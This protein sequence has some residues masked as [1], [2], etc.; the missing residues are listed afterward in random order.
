MQKRNV[1]QTGKNAF[2][3]LIQVLHISARPC[4]WFRCHPCLTSLIHIT[5]RE[6][7]FL[8]SRAWIAE[9]TPKTIPISFRRVSITIFYSKIIQSKLIKAASTC[10]P[11]RRLHW[12]RLPLSRNLL[13]FLTSALSSN[14][15]CAHLS[16]SYAYAFSRSTAGFRCVYTS[17]LT[18]R[19][20][21]DEATTKSRKK[22]FQTLTSERRR[23][24]HPSKTNEICGI[25]LCSVHQLSGV[26]S[27]RTRLINHI[28]CRWWTT[29]Y[30]DACTRSK[31]I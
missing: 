6:L 22:W 3:F 11:R 29:H 25:N 27:G 26:E 5:G 31:S 19:L 20:Q 17:S 4:L 12:Q 10:V 2:G 7:I 18:H 28:R 23:P 30:T 9:I 14:V 13:N 16:F 15:D 8:F 24:L 1:E 21:N